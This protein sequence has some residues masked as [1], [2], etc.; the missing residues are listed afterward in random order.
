M[1]SIQT[2]TLSLLLLYVNKIQ[3]N[4]FTCYTQC[5]DLFGYLCKLANTELAYIMHRLSMFTNNFKKR[6]IHFF[7][8]LDVSNQLTDFHDDI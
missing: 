6:I 7:F 2:L 1:G 5:L 8:C 3:K 4:F